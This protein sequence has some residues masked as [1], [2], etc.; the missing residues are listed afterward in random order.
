MCKQNKKWKKCKNKKE[1]N[2][3]EIYNVISQKHIIVLKVEA[4]YVFFCGGCFKGLS[5]TRGWTI[6]I[7]FKNIPINQYGSIFFFVLWILKKKPREPHY[8]LINRFCWP[9]IVKSSFICSHMCRHVLLVLAFWP[10]NTTM[11]W[12]ILLLM[13]RSSP[14]LLNIKRENIVNGCGVMHIW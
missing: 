9:A 1:K 5:S 14:L 4:D 10:G 13:R 8:Y 3:N 11:V 12:G 6:T 2:W 7:V